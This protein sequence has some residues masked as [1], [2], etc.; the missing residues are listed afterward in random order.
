MTIKYH[1]IHFWEGTKLMW[2]DIKT[3]RKILNKLRKGNELTYRERRQLRRVFLDMLK[4]IPM[5]IIALIPFLEAALPFLLWMFPNMLPSRFQSEHMKLEKRK[6]LLTA[7]IGL[8]SFFEDTLHEF[9]KETKRKQEIIGS[10]SVESL[11]KLLEK[12]KNNQDITNKQILK[13]ASL[14]DDEMALDN[15]SQSVLANMCRYMELNSYGTTTMLRTRLYQKIRSIR[16]ED[17]VKIFLEISSKYLFIY[18]FIYIQGIRKEGLDNI[19]ESLLKQLL[20]ER[21]MRSDF[22]EWVLRANMNKWLEL[23]LDN[24]VPITLLIMSRI[25][26][27]QH[28]P[29]QDTTEMLKDTISTISDATT[30]EMLVE[31]GG[32]NDLKLEKE[33]IERQQKLIDDEE[34]INDH[35]KKE[36][37][38]NNNINNINIRD[39]AES[40]ETLTSNSAVDP[41]KHE[42]QEIKEKLNEIKYETLQENNHKTK[43]KL[44]ARI[45]KIIEKSVIIADET[46]NKFKNTL[47]RFNDN[48]ND[49]T[50]E[51]L[52]LAL[53]DTLIE[54]EKFSD[55]QIEEFLKELDIRKNSE[56][57]LSKRIERLIDDYDEDIDIKDL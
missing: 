42:I 35:D 4:F 10:S 50:E 41:E 39:L 45:N 15:A 32:I 29:G 3:A 53:K 54:S 37:E 48:D 52:K 17:A 27:L 5:I 14:F 2:T 30:K 56:P 20:R 26:T 12:I 49:I 23:S 6:K 38:N 44:S 51:E 55:A 7:R 57:K 47:Q 34:L 28:V 22:Q 43:E 40:V 11:E 33:I 18:S 31:K 24:E 9:V 21:G 36:E 16:K 1:I 8:A 46:G 25:F 19:P 13:L